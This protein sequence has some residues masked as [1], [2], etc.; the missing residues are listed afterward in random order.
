VLLLVQVAALN[1]ELLVGKFQLD[2]ETGEII[3][4]VELATEDGLGM[5]TVLS[6]LDSLTHTADARY[7]DLKRAAAGTG[8]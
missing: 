1:Y 3:L 2:A 7:P 6:A 8:L 4:S 5:A